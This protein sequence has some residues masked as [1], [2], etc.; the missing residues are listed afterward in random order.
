[1]EFR[2]YLRMLQQG[3]WL[4]ALSALAALALSLVSL[5]QDT[6]LYRTSARFIVSPTTA[7]TYERDIIYSLDT[8][9]QRSIISTYAEVLNSDRMYHD[10][11]AA[12]S[13]GR[14]KFRTTMS[15]QWF[16]PKRTSLNSP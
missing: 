14:R 13:S 7:I 8:L 10:V 16:S 12:L 2:I 1:M 3:W 4:I 6:P 15:R 11:A 9:D 5:Y